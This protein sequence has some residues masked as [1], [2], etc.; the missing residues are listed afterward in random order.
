M[1]RPT[2][3]TAPTGDPGP[4]P[5]QPVA[6]ER[7]AL[8]AELATRAT[9]AGTRTLLVGEPGIGKSTVLDLTVATAR[10]E[11]AVVL[12]VRAAGSH[13]QPFAGLIDL[14]HPL[15]DADLD[16]LPPVQRLAVEVA[17]ARRT[18]DRPLPPTALRTAV[19]T[20]VEGLLVHGPVCLA[21]DDWPELD[22]ETA[23]VVRHVLT[24]P[25]RDGRAPALLATQGLY[26]LLSGAQDR[27]DSDLFRP[28]DVLPVP[29]LSLGSLAD[30]VT[31]RTGRRWSSTVLGELHRV[32]AG[33]PLWAAELSHPQL[34]TLAA[35]P[36]VTTPPSLA[37]VLATR[38]GGLTTGART[39]LAVVAALGRVA[40]ERLADVLP[41]GRAG[42]LDALDAAVLRRTP[43]GL[44]PV[45]PLVGAA[46]LASFGAGTR[47]DLHRLVA[48]VATTAGE[49]AEHLDLA[50]PPGPDEEVAAALDAAVAESRAHGATAAAL[51]QARQALDRTPPATAAREERAVTVAEVAFAA[52]VLDGVLDLADLPLAALPGVLLDRALPL[53]VEALVVRHGEGRAFDLLARL[54]DELPD[55]PV[56]GAVLDAYR[57]EDGSRPMAE[58]NARAE[59]AVAVLTGAQRAPSSLHRALTTL[60]QLRLDQGRGLD[61]ELLAR[62]AALEESL[63]LV[64]VLDGARAVLAVTAVQVDDVATS[65]Q[66]LEQ[67]LEDATAGGDETLAGFSAFHLALVSVLR[68]DRDRAARLL[69]EHGHAAPWAESA[70]PFVVRARGVLALADGDP[71]ALQEVLDRPGRSGSSA[72]QAWTRLAL[73]GMAAARDGRWAEAVRPLTEAR[74]LADAAGVRDP[75]RRLWLDV[76]LAETLCALD[77]PEEAERVAG[78]LVELTGGGDRPLLTGQLLRVQG[79]VAAV[80]GDLATAQQLLERSV[81]VLATTGYP[82]EHGA[83][84]LELGRLLRR[85]RARAR[86]QSLLRQARAVAGDAG[87]VPLQRRAEQLLGTRGPA[88]PTALTA[89]EQRVAEA[90]AAGASNREIAAA[91][92]VSVRTVESHLAAVYRKL[93]VTSRTRLARALAD[94]A[95]HRAAG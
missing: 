47:S 77:R 43:Q 24:R 55:E 18:V 85:R 6:P 95:G 17:L 79:L 34:S 92:F 59:A 66:A 91:Q 62:A 53:L 13:G 52:G 31:E 60:V 58:R 54:A 46:A 64:S 88:G 12:D 29:P 82:R 35:A 74:D 56:A 14:M 7:R 65:T 51:A 73:A 78:R 5:E 81:A 94:A 86:G 26:G 9:A 38:I 10:A 37:D 75:G 2:S 3:P 49:R 69:A 61:R 23:V 71:E 28:S 50:T 84:L 1:D 48:A 89:T 42:L 40:P 80:R 22:P 4:A 72:V 45:H 63:P 16:A 32:T 83:S 87:D 90:V 68:G 19:A 20:W 15:Q 8:L 11:G 67:L 30:L 41:A 33:N 70:P 93:Q 39:A 27:V 57:A 21:V 36:D 76:D 44:E 25:A